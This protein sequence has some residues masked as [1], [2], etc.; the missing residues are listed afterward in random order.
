ME[1]I[2][3]FNQVDREFIDYATEIV[4]ENCLKYEDEY[5]DLFNRIDI[6]MARMNEVEK[7]I[8]INEKYMEEYDSIIDEIKDIN[9][10]FYDLLTRNCEDIKGIKKQLRMNQDGRLKECINVFKRDMMGANRKFGLYNA[11]MM[12]NRQALYMGRTD[13]IVYSGGQIYALILLNLKEEFNSKVNEYKTKTKRFIGKEIIKLEK[14]IESSNKKEIK[15]EDKR[16]PQKIFDY[17][18]MCKFANE[19]GY[20]DIRQNGS[21]VAFRHKTSNNVVPIPQHTRDFNK[22]LMYGLQK[23]LYNNSKNRKLTIINEEM[24]R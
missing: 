14:I 1:W 21:H 23:Q 16:Q 2:K 18:T 19:L 17:R 6:T 12:S 22:G 7:A 11:K 5:M 10:T 24:F 9:N 13:N 15:K 3:K 20:E 8:E 4:I